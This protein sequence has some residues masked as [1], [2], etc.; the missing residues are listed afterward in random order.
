MEKELAA[1]LYQYKICPLPSIG[2]LFLRP[3]NATF[4]AGENKFLAPIPVIELSAT[5]NPANALIQYL[6]SE[7]KIDIPEAKI[8]LDEYCDTLNNLQP[9]QE[10]PLSFAGSFYKDESEQ[11][12]FKSMKLPAA[13]FPELVAERVVH[14]DIS[15]DILV[16]DIQTN[17][18]A[19][20]E[21]LNMEGAKKKYW[22]LAASILA[23][24]GFAL[25][26]LYYSQYSKLF[27]FGNVQQVEPKVATKT[28][29]SNI[30]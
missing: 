29:I 10:Y 5:E 24:L 15:H 20:S 11:L 12:H 13:F 9:Y 30:K 27:R 19:M 8:A 26:G 16:G 4:L 7:M 17:T 14:Q 2:S 28:Y 1:Y 22:W 6:S 18:A 21:L 23:M 25:V 3:G